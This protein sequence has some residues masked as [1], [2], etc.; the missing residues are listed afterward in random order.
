MSRINRIQRLGRLWLD[1][2]PRF[3]SP[4]FTS[5]RFTSP[6]FTSPRFTSPR[7]A[8]P[9][10]TGPVQSSPAQSSPRNTICHSRVLWFHSWVV[11]RFWIILPPRA[12]W[13]YNESFDFTVEW[14][15]DFELFCLHGRSE[16]TTSPLISQLSGDSLQRTMHTWIAYSKLTIFSHILPKPES[17][18]RQFTQNTS[19]SILASLLQYCWIPGGG[20]TS[21]YEATGDV[22]LDGVAFSRLDWL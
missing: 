17:C 3:T 5:P 1:T 11:R 18:S 20:G 2:S 22:P 19:R 13:N 8:S 16:I 4:R 12:K 21:L 10:F 14:F 7:F 6:R 15:A 9:R